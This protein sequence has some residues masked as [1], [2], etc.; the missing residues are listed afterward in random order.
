MKTELRRMAILQEIKQAQES[1]SAT[2]L[3]GLFNVSR[4]SIAQDIAILKA[5]KEPIIATPKGYVFQNDDKVRFIITC[6]HTNEHTKSELNCIVDFGGTIENV[7]VKHP[8]YGELSAPLNISSRYD[9]N[10]F[11]EKSERYQASSLSD[12]NEG[13]HMHTINCETKTQSEAILAMLKE[14]KYLYDN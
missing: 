13:I 5:R 6:K 4:Q 7:I 1:I 12:L 9:V 8:I 2:K 11:I 14:K 10:I 3:A